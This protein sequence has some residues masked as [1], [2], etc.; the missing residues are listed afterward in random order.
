MEDAEP[1]QRGVDTFALRRTWPRL[2]PLPRSCGSIWVQIEALRP[3]DLPLHQ[4]QAVFTATQRELWCLE[5]LETEWATE[6]I[7]VI[8]PPCHCCKYLAYRLRAY[9]I[10]GFKQTLIFF[11]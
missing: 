11:Y 2:P 7:H 9:K 3:N 1:A 5:P 10:L 8:L 4:Q 6:N